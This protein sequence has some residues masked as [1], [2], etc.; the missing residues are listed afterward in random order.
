[1]SDASPSFSPQHVALANAFDDDRF[2]TIV[3]WADKQIS[4][5]ISIREAAYRRERS[6]LELHC[7]QIRVLTRAT[8][9]TVKTLGSGPREEADGA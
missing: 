5:W 2:E 4:L 3:E 7:E 9:Q 1:M 8:F 6:T